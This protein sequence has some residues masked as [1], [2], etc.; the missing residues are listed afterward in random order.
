MT[1]NSPA[2]RRAALPAALFAAAL[3]A[4]CSQ[5][6]APQPA[7]ATPSAAP[8]PALD[9]PTGEPVGD[10]FP[11]PGRSVIVEAVAEAVSRDD[12]RLIA[13]VHQDDLAGLERALLFTVQVA[14]PFDAVARTASPVI[15]VDGTPLTNTVLGPERVVLQAV[16]L[17]PGQREGRVRVQTG[18]FGSLERT[19]SEPVVISAPGGGPSPD[20]Q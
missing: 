9:R 11:D 17:S 18:W 20:P 4:A 15:V 16:W 3:L 1:S 10:A 13:I 7:H 12:E 5:E 8:A 14:E 19:I 6:V 2:K